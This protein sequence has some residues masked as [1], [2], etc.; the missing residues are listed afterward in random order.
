[1]S[2][3]TIER[4]LAPLEKYYMRDHYEEIAVNQP[5]EVWCRRNKPD[6]Y[7]R[8]W[9]RH[10]D[11]ALTLRYL[12]TLCQAIANTFGHKFN[13]DDP[14]K[15][16]TVFATLPPFD[17]RFAAIA[18]NHMVYDQTLP[19]GGIGICIRKGAKA[20]RSH[21][22]EFSDWGL[23][24]GRGVQKGHAHLPTIH[25]PV[26]DAIRA[27]KDAVQQGCNILISGGTSTGKTTLFNRILEEVDTRTRIITVEDTRE[28][29]LPKHHNHAHLVLSRTDRNSIFGYDD[30]IDVIM[31]FTPDIVLVGEISTT[32]AGTL[33]RLTGTGH[34][35]MMTTI[36]ASSV[37]DCYDVLYERISGCIP[38]LDR[39]KTIEKIREN[40]C[41]IQ[42]SRD[43]GGARVITDI[44]APVPRDQ[45]AA[46]HA[47]ATTI[48]A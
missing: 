1:M 4:M 36:H 11:P 33:W 14:K 8:I 2:L 44:K 28:I 48:A 39:A 16:S 45:Q 46:H 31:R 21:Q 47:A 15:P 9:V 34:G 37:T 13:P 19:E 25:D 43:M 17:H 22:V 26:L 12:R 7:N 5:G 38:N 42:M 35:A 18:G 40:F 24:E 3:A 29:K 23:V 27:L 6:A 41:I 30:A 10:N 20:S 32:N